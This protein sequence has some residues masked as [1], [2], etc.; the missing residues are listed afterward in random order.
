MAQVR[1][2]AVPKSR[3][4]ALDRRERSRS[5]A[6]VRKR[7]KTGMA[8]THSD[9]RTDARRRCVSPS[10]AVLAPVMIVVDASIAI[11]VSLADALDRL[12]GRNAI[13]PPLMWSEAASVL[14]EMQWRR[15]ISAELASAAL[16]RLRA[17]PIK[18]RRPAHLLTSAWQIA[19]SLGWAKTYDAEYVAL[20]K[21]LRCALLTTDAKLARAARDV[22]Q[23]LGPADL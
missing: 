6:C 5:S 3:D 23:I 18:S 4:S 15:A 12:K 20:A 14:H 19:N 11:E 16:E 10:S 7:V 8:S 22:V 13:A 1:T 2:T 17:G 21:L 9:R